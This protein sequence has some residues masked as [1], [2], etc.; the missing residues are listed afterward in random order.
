MFELWRGPS[1]R[2]NST[3]PVLSLISG[4]FAEVPIRRN[5]QDQSELIGR[6]ID[7]SE[8]KI[9]LA[10]YQKKSEFG[11]GLITIQGL[12]ME[13]VAIP[14][15]VEEQSTLIVNEQIIESSQKNVKE[16]L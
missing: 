3:L 7:I 2:Q 11:P 16:S 8:S 12:S 10:V 5:C 14:Y 1:F 13:K 4:L 9:G 6:D 15:I